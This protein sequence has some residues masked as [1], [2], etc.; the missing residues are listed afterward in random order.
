MMVFGW[1]WFVVVLVFG[2][3]FGVS[4]PSTSKTVQPWVASPSHHEA[5]GSHHGYRLAVL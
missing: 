4:I 5:G 2:V 1:L 3:C